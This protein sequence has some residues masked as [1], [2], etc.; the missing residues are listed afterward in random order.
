M[1]LDTPLPAKAN[2]EA[3]RLPYFLWL[4]KGGIYRELY[5]SFSSK[6]YMFCLFYIYIGHGH[7][8]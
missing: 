2:R 8:M 1:T 5:N 6:I 3:I 7:Y 4:G